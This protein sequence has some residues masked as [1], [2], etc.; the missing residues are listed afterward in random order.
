MDEAYLS[1]SLEEYRLIYPWCYK[2]GYA[3]GEYLSSWI[4]VLLDHRLCHVSQ[5]P[6]PYKKLS[7]SFRT[8]GFIAGHQVGLCHRDLHIVHPV[9]K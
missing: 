3:A 6:D 2:S 9:S 1:S 8:I 5:S 4:K 7:R